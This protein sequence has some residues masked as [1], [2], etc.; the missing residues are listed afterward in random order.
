MRSCKNDL[1]EFLK[2]HPNREFESYQLAKQLKTAQNTINGYLVDMETDSLV[3]RRED[4]YYVYWRLR[5][6]ELS[7][8]LLLTRKWNGRL[9][10]DLHLLFRD[11]T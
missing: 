4:G 9:A 8:R 5:V 3:V 1:Y 11:N 7:S 2:K 6:N 10:V